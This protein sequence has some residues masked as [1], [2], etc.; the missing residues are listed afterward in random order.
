MKCTRKKE[1]RFDDKDENANCP[2]PV[3]K[4][5]SK[6]YDMKRFKDLHKSASNSRKVMCY[7][8]TFVLCS[9]LGRH[10]STSLADLTLH[11]SVKLFQWL[12]WFVPRDFKHSTRTVEETHWFMFYFYNALWHK[13]LIMDKKDRFKFTY[14][15]QYTKDQKHQSEA[16]IKGEEEEE[17][18]LFS[19]LLPLY[20]PMPHE[21]TRC[22]FLYGTRKRISFHS[23][24]FVEELRKTPNCCSIGLDGGHWFY[25]DQPEK[26]AKYI[27]DFLNGI[28]YKY[29]KSTL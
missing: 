6:L 9:L 26:S 29:A 19:G 4:D 22:M 3:M 27:K 24:A 28:V 7:Q 13:I 14:T 16:G 5:R 11:T 25:L 8:L 18:K 10:V 17:R 20:C 12:E 15:S 2:S 1:V 21:N 23:E